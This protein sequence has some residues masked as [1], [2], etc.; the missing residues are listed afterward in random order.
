[1]K[2]TELPKIELHVHLDCSLSYEVVS[3]LEPAITREN[4]HKYFCS[5]GS[6]RNLLDYL[7]RAVRAVALMQDA[8]ALRLVTTDLFDQFQAE[9]VL[10]AEIRYAPM[11]HTSGGMKVEEVVRVVD[12]AV[13]ENIERTGIECGIILCTLRHFSEEESMQT[14]LLAETLRESLVVGFDLAADEAGFPVDNHVAAFNYAHEKNI[15]CTSH[16]GESCGPDS[17]WETLEVF[18]PDRLG[19]GVQSIDDPSLVTHLQKTG[20]HLEI[21]P[22]SNIETRIYPDIS[23]HPVDRLYRQG[24]A[25]SINTDGRTISNT[26][27]TREYE[28]L[29]E[30]FGW[31]VEDFM[32]CNRMAIDASFISNRRKD[33]L[34][35]KLTDSLAKWSALE[36]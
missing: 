32:A 11:L 4:Y 6:C 14:V 2:L 13:G 20:I 10:Y 27:L 25:L 29:Q 19:H 5:D 28:K 17:I 8:R 18:R 7:K 31:K 30:A 22:T 34:H 16:A 26:T 21:C 12:E 15:H 24:L 35:K 3:K 23:Q 9:N 36:Q 33:Q 1:M